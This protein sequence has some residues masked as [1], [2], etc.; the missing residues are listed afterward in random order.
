MSQVRVVCGYLDNRSRHPCKLSGHSCLKGDGQN[1][2]DCGPF[3]A[4]AH[5]S[6]QL[7]ARGK[8]A[9]D[10]AKGGTTA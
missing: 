5:N 6:E 4:A 2:R 7:A 3:L 9:I 1:F 10:N 8:A